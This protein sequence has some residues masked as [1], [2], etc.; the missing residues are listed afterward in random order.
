MLRFAAVHGKAKFG[1]IPN[2]YEKPKNIVLNK[3]N[4]QDIIAV[5]SYVDS[6]QLSKLH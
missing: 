3:I 1:M 5:Y 6:F 4:K 2:G